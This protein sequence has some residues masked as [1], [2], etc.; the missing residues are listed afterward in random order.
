MTGID[1]YVYLANS[2]VEKWYFGVSKKM[3]E[4]I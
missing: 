2:S 1:Q 3:N 4:L